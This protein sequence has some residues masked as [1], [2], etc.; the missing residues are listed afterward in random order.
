[1][2]ISRWK[3]YGLW[4]SI[5]SFIPLI[6][7]GFGLNILPGNYSEII[8]ALLGILVMAGIISNPTTESKWFSD[9]TSKTS[10]TLP[11]EE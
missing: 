5:A 11:K 8:N 7:Q 3:N 2:D 6:L 10:N 9:D 4:V 1:M